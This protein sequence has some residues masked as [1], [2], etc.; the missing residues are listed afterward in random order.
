MAGERDEP[1]RGEAIDESRSQFIVT[2]HSE[3]VAPADPLPVVEDHA[4]AGSADG[5]RN[6]GETG[7][8]NRSGT[9]EGDAGASVSIV[10]LAMTAALALI[11]G[12][13]GAWA[14]D[15]FLAG[16]RGATDAQ[17]SGDIAREPAGEGRTG[18][19]AE[20]G[21]A[22]A[23]SSPDRSE[24]LPAGD[25]PGPFGPSGADSRAERESGRIDQLAEQLSQLREEMQERPDPASGS[26]LEQL[27]K[28]LGEITERLDAIERDS[29]EVEGLARRIEQRS[30]R[31]DDISDLLDQMESRLTTLSD[32]ADAA[33]RGVGISG[34][35]GTS[36]S[37]SEGPGDS[38][39]LI[40]RPASP[41]GTPDREAM[42]DTDTNSDPS[43]ML[44]RVLRPTAGDD[45]DGSETALERG[46]GQFR[47]DDFASARETFLDLLE[48]RPE[49]PRIWYFAALATGKATGDWKGEA[50]RLVLQG[51]DRERA[52]RLPQAA[53]DA[54]F[55]D[56]TERQG[57]EWLRFYRRRVDN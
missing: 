48:Q 19:G 16:P 40:P 5:P 38:P 36:G 57:S 18:G 25:R 45:D 26:Q 28:R 8:G 33:A 2:E 31:L 52:D 49:D 43:A 21:D 44:R 22:M 55:A 54:A 13:A 12:L 9:Q 14:Y 29:G 41:G 1:R 51:V 56:L 27:S 24:A 32:Q 7:K 15:A 17:A 35:G 50:E 39:A 34:I 30:D 3:G 42:A 20:R 11:F 46:I 6:E 47:A 10:S 37:G 53:I 23:E 4:G